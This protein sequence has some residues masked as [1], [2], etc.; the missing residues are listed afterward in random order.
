MTG[1][2]LF[3]ERN[4]IGLLS[5]SNPPLNI[6]TA[7]VRAA[8]ASTVEQI[9]NSQLRVLIVTGAGDRA[10]CAGADLREEEGLTSATVRG[11]LESDRAVYD[12][13]QELPIPV[14]AAV[15][16]HC[17]GGGLELAL[18][19]DIRIAAA[20]AKFCAAGAKVGLVASTTRL[21]YL[22]G[23]AAAAEILLTA[24]T[25]D[26]SEAVRLGVA[27]KAVPRDRLM[28]EALELA[29]EIASRAPLAVASAKEAI[30]EAAE[31]PFDQAMER[32]LDRFADLSMTSDHKRAL[33]A[34]FKRE[35]PVFEG[36]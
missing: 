4:G 36:K 8:F 6:I 10:F 34:F 12:A 35:Q 28:E 24:R 26:G 7:D 32:E 16:G 11:F 13:T 29:E 22:L 18:A 31:L 20:E 15:N 23:P 3:E 19:C 5:L 30:R 25:F 2:V 17:M 1:L 14:I 21:T 9:R 27:S 33:A